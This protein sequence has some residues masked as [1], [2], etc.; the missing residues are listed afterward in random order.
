MKRNV[1]RMRYEG[2]DQMADVL[3]ILR[4]GVDP[5]LEGVIGLF[6]T[7]SRAATNGTGTMLQ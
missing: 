4:K 3:L 2:R 6:E 5:L 1:E 7:R